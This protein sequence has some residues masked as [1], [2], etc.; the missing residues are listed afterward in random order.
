MSASAV[1]QS[2]RGVWP[3][4]GWLWRVGA[5]RRGAGAFRE[6]AQQPS[7]R[8]RLLPPGSARTGHDPGTDG[9]RSRRTWFSRNCATTL[10]PG[11]APPARIGA[12]GSSRNA[13]RP[14]G[15]LCESVPLGQVP[16]GCGRCNSPA[17]AWW[18][19]RPGWVFG[20]AHPHPGRCA[21]RPL[22]HAGEVNMAAWRVRPGGPAAEGAARGSRVWGARLFRPTLDAGW[23][24]VVRRVASGTRWCSEPMKSLL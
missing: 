20:A 8:G 9:H 22:P 10:P 2:H 17:P 18:R 7:R 23:A 6:I 11:Q 24:G 5:G 1:V 3:T 19:R 13:Q 16:R 12:E 15:R 4:W 14:S 21:T